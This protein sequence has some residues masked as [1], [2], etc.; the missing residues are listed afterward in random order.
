MHSYNANKINFVFWFC[1]N[2]LFL[3]LYVLFLF[4]L[5]QVCTNNFLL[6][7]DIYLWL[8]HLQMDTR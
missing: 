4:L 5:R 2:L 6:Y 8:V 1:L 7:F 3:G